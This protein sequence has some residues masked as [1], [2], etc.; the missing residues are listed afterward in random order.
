MTRIEEKKNKCPLVS[1]IAICHRHDKYVIET[2]D[3]IQNQTYRNVELIII[4]NVKDNCENVIDNWIKSKTFNNKPI[5]IQNENILTVTLNCNLGLSKCSG[6]YFQVI[7][8]DDVM[9]LDKIEKQVELFETLDESYACVYSDMMMIDEESKVVGSFFES[10]RES[11]IDFS[12]PEGNLQKYFFTSSF[13]PAPSILLRRS[14]IIEIGGYNKMWVFEDW[15]LYIELMKKNYNFVPIDLPLV[16]YR[17]LENGL[18]KQTT[19]ESLIFCISLFEENHKFIDKNDPSNIKKWMSFIIRL[20]H[21]DRSSRHFK[22]FVKKNKL[23]FTNLREI[24]RYFLTLIKNSIV[25][26]V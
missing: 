22:F 18:G 2:L 23:N 20:Q 25:E 14:A 1:I 15:P 12:L 3:S 5:F 21:F 26:H 8:C 17:I 6:K 16:K 11:I 13:V 7:S 9:M 24:S 19:S 10:K 4:N